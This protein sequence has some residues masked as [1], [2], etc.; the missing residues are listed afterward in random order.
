MNAIVQQGNVRLRL[1]GS[2]L[3]VSTWYTSAY[4]VEGGCSWG[5][6]WEDGDLIGT[7]PTECLPIGH[8]GQVWNSTGDIHFSGDTEVCNTWI[9]VAGRPCAEVH[10]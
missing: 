7:G 1:T 9:D 3:Y 10:D 6:F 5:G 4:L 8:F 2:G